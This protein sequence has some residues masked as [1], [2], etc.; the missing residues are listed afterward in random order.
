[1]RTNP[2][3]RLA[4]NVIVGILLG[5]FIS[6]MLSGCSDELPLAPA[7]SAGIAG[8]ASAEV[9]TINGSKTAA[10]ISPTQANV[11]TTISPAAVATTSSATSP[12]AV[13]PAAV[14]V[15]APVAASVVSDTM[16]LPQ[17]KERY[18]LSWDGKLEGDATRSLSC[19]ATQCRYETHASVV[20]LASFSEISDFQW[21]HGQVEFQRY[22]RTLQLLFKQVARIEKQADGS[23][24]SERR[25]KVYQYAGKAGLV[26]ILNIEV[27]LRADRL[28]NR[29]PKA[30]YP[31][32]DSKGISAISLHREADETL[33]VAGKARHSE[34]YVRQDGKRK[35]TLWLDPAQAF[36]PLQIIHQDGAETYRMIWLGDAAK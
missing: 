12:T 17:T 29:A 1:M 8:E 18:H 33:T 16:P 20:G 19:K 23:I 11:V 3:L 25:G 10:R 34:V 32:A 22:E 14:S 13:A 24:R 6:Q 21:V 15:T 28:A 35:T 27:Q 36:L 26:D 31:L 9:E 5:I 7:P 2:R 4:I 30:S